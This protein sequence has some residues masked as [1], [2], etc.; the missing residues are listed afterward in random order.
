MKLSG[1]PVAARPVVD[2][3]GRP[4]ARAVLREAMVA[5]RSAPVASL[6]TLVVIAAMCAAVLLTSGRTVG[7]QRAVVGSI[8]SVGTRTVTVRADPAAGV[9]TS[10]LDRLA[11][12]DGVTWAAAFGT[13]ED[14]RNAA[15]PGTRVPLRLA[16]AHDWAVSG[17]DAAVGRGD[18]AYASALALAQLGMLGRAGYARAESG[19]GWAVVGPVDVPDHL[20]G[21]EPL[22][23]APQPSGDP[24]PVTVIVVVADRPELV[25]PVSEAVSGVLAAHDPSRVTVEGSEALVELRA[26]VD[27][28]LGAF[29]RGLTLGILGLSGLLTAATLFGVVMMRRKDFG[30]RRALGATRGTVVALLLAQTTVVAVLGAVVGSGA[31]LVALALTGDALPGAE[32]TLAVGVLAVGVAVVAALAP[33]L[34]AASR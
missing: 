30:R 1:E 6:L 17:I 20:V 5:A 2:A 9:D 34:V 26:L 18:V 13:A 29:G 10:V 19:S 4:R 22:L 33:A 24:Q 27:R 28:Q 14:V 31:A 15:F 23:V 12:L 11:T 25:G 16:W 21:L 32:Y 3:L 7:A 8:E